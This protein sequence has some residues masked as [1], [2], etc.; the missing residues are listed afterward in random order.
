MLMDNWSNTPHPGMAE[1]LV[2]HVHEAAS[3][4][5]YI[6]IEAGILLVNQ[7]TLVATLNEALAGD[8]AHES[9]ATRSI[10]ITTKP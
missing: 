8:Q 5:C 1:E 4:F 3:I 9:E 6:N 7:E 10:P 2:S